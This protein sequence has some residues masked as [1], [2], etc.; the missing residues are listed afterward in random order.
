MKTSIGKLVS[1]AALM[2]FLVVFFACQKEASHSGMSSVPAGT[3]KLSVSLTDGPYDFQKVLID[4]KS[5]QVL[6]DTCHHVS[7]S[8]DQEDDGREQDGQGDDGEGHHERDST[9]SCEVWSNLQINPGIYDLLTLRNGKDTLLGASFIPQGNIR[10]IKITLGT[11]NSIMAD[12]VTSPLQIKDHKDYVIIQI[13][14]EH[15]DSIAPGNF[16]LL[17]DFDLS[18]SIRFED[19]TYWLKPV[20]RAFCKKNTGTIEGTVGPDGSFGMIKAFNAS[21][22]AYALPD[23]DEDGKFKIRGLTEGAYSVLIQGEHG[24]LDSTITGVQVTKGR[25]IDLGK[26]ILHQ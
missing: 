7:N 3:T 5:I 4:I 21:D 24:Y 18:K 16:N 25:E 1:P 14:R 6:V 15:L 22:T 20:L 8:N 9:D 23:R 2:T 10:K 17:L 19:G 13:R 11:N 26:I 12:G